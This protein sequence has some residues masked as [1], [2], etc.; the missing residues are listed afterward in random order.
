MTKSSTSMTKS[1]T[2]MTKK[3]LEGFKEIHP[4]SYK[5]I[6]PGEY[7]RYSINNEIRKGGFVRKNS[8]PDYL[9]LINYYRKITWCVQYKQPSLKIYV[10]T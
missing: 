3:E 10:K 4:R 1:S 5:K 2:S 6:Q 7:V 9:V 8:F